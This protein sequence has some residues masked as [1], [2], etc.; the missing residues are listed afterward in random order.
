MSPKN[1]TDVA[2]RPLNPYKLINNTDDELNEAE[3]FWEDAILESTGLFI[4]EDNLSEVP[5]K[6]LY[7]VMAPRPR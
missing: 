7:L 1:R 2:L 5:K 6:K 4:N 3:L